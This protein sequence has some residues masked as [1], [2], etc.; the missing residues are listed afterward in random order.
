MLQILP[1]LRHFYTVSLQQ[2]HDIIDLEL[3]VFDEE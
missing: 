2:C 1:D 3:L